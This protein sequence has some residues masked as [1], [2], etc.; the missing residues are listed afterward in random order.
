M[1]DMKWYVLG[2]V[3][4]GQELKIRDALRR[5]SLDCFVPLCYKVKAIRGQRKRL[6]VPAI[7]GLMFI[8]GELDDLKELLRYRKQGLFLRKST[9]SNREEYLTVSDKDMQNFM[10][11]AAQAGEH[12]RYYRPE[13][14]QLRPGDKIRVNGGMFDGR[15][16]V[17]Q[18][19]KGHRHKQ[20]IVSIPGI[21]FAAVELTPD[22]V[23]MVGGDD[24]AKQCQPS[25]HAEEDTKALLA[26]AKRLLFEISTSFQQEKEYYLL[27][28]EMKLTYQRLQP[29]KAY[30]P[31]KE[32]ELA[33]ALYLAAV[34]LE[35]ASDIATY[36]QRLRAAIEKLQHTSLL[37]LRAQ[38]YVAVLSGDSDLKAVV[39][40]RFEAMKSQSLSIKQRV[41][42]EEFETLQNL[43]VGPG[44]SDRCK[45]K[46]L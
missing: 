12:I 35:A 33:L 37:K 29:I 23:E 13:E 39:Q 38:M 25:K 46:I 42:L 40:K 24:S 41:L 10:A 11:F 44:P 43:S 15:E 8:R 21:V 1:A 30:L 9:F 18:R 19:I 17:I 2:S 20:L 34:K 22:L 28:S 6:L 16:G 3:S 26:L 31:A 14:I 4:R 45:E 5:E 36:E 32:A 27:V 7:S